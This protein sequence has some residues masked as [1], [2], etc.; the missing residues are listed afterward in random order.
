VAAYLTDREEWDVGF[1]GRVSCEQLEDMA[2]NLGG[3]ASDIGHRV[4][5]EAE[6]D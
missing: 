1:D 4:Y 6:V 2:K 3:K 5:L